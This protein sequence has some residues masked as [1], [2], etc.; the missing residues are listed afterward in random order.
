MQI[1]IELPDDI[2][3]LKAMLVA[4]ALRDQRKDE[5]IA[6]LEKLVAAFKQA[7]ADTGMSWD[8]FAVIC[9]HQVTVP[10]LRTFTEGSGIPAESLVV[11]L[12]DLFP[13]LHWALEA[14]YWVVAGTV[15]VFPVTW[16]MLWA[17]GKR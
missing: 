4:A 8:D 14:L 12:P 17:A 2:A 15:W 13:R 7:L 9:V 5:R 1:T 3:A 6:Q 10:Y 16:L 11:T